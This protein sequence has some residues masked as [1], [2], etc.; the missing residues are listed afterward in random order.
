MS[1]QLELYQLGDV[2]QIESYAG[3]INLAIREGSRTHDILSVLWKEE[4]RFSPHVKPHDIVKSLLEV[5][6]NQHRYMTTR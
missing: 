1:E 4:Q 2:E 5:A 3:N 6:Y